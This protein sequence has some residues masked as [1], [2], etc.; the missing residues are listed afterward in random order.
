MAS[1]TLTP[2]KPNRHRTGK[3]THDI[4]ALK[5]DGIVRGPEL[6][7][8]TSRDDW[9]EFT[10]NWY[11]TWRKAPQA[12]LFE[13]TDWQR[14]GLLAYI[15]ERFTVRPSASSLQEI[16]Q[17]EERLGATVV[18]R[19]RARMTIQH[20]DDPDGGEARLAVVRDLSDHF[21]DRLGD[22]TDGSSA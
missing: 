12:Q 13:A 5:D 10:V 9:S 3:P 20:P 4:V 17:N 8:L 2:S 18:D 14:L 6:R 7:D 15:V 21:A 16:R 19:L 11:E 1:G 22:D